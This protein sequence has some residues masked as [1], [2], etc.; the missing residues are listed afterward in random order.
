M[1]D[2]KLWNS[3]AC[4]ASLSLDIDNEQGR[5]LF[6]EFQKLG[7]RALNAQTLIY[8]QHPFFRGVSPLGL[9]LLAQ[10]PLPC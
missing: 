5:L 8:A 3:A 2:G 1:P 6:Q 10:F 9:K 4:G 7:E